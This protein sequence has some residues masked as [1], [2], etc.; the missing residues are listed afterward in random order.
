[1]ARTAQ[2]II[3]GGGV[4]GCLDISV[5]L[6]VYSFF[7]VTPIRLLQGIACGLIGF[8]AYDEGWISAAL[9]LCLHF[10]IA[11]TATAVYVGAIRWIPALLHEPYLSGAL[12]AV[13]VYFFMQCIVI[14]LSAVRKPPFSLRLTLVGLA[15]HII[16]V[17]LP[18]S[19]VSRRYLLS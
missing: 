1:M 10:I 16:C 9:G 5:A 18:I 17:G 2:A 15:I 12:Y 11:L 6:V 4:S 8:R 19:L 3:A 14:P 13:A 7:G